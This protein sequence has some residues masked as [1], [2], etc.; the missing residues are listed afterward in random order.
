VNKTSTT[1]EVGLAYN[2]KIEDVNLGVEIART[3]TGIKEA[4][5]NVSKVSDDVILSVNLGK[6]WYKNTTS[7][8]IGVN[9]KVRF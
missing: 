1:G 8:V 6:N 5:L 3:T 9:L 4:L 7:D 2:T